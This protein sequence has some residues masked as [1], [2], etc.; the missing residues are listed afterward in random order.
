MLPAIE[1]GHDILASGPPGAGTSTG[2]LLAVLC[3]VLSTP[4]TVPPNKA[5]PLAMVL[6]PSRELAMQLAAEGAKLVAKTQMTVKCITGGAELAQQVGLGKQSLVHVE[7]LRIRCCCCVVEESAS[8][9]SCTYCSGSICGASP[10][11]LKSTVAK[12]SGLGV[13]RVPCG[14]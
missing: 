10:Q 6:C 1:A 9:F 8:I 3:K 5:M 13:S 2:A 11:E 12:H 7:Q 4:R 14:H